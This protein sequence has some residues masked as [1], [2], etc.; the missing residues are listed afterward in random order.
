MKG[1]KT[2]REGVLKPSQQAARKRVMAPTE[3]ERAEQKLF[4]KQSALIGLGFTPGWFMSSFFYE[5]DRLPVNFAALVNFGALAVFG[6]LGLF[7][8]I[9]QYRARVTTLPPAERAIALEVAMLRVIAF[10]A[11][12][13]A[14]A[15]YVQG[16][17]V[18]V[19]WLIREVLP[20]SAALSAG[21]VGV[22]VTIAAGTLLFLLRWK[23]R[24]IYAS[25]E[26]VTAIGLAAH[27]APKF[28]ADDPLNPAFLLT[29]IT[30]SIYLF[31]RGADNVHQAF[32]KRDEDLFLKAMSAVAQ[33][34]Q[35]RRASKSNEN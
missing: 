3:Q 21:A 9:R 4:L 8:V 13:Q 12:S 5:T 30:A 20:R 14:V 15:G 27:L 1:K 33:Q 10:G 34:W 26:L 22:G 23:A 25:L 6:P 17:Y 16:L 7:L 18:F 24:S 28:R 35:K 32:L 19:G 11:F 2:L 31:V 29:F